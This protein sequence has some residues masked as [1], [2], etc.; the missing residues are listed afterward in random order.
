MEHIGILLQQETQIVWFNDL[1]SDPPGDPEKKSDIEKA[2]KSS[3]VWKNTPDPLLC[4]CSFYDWWYSIMHTA[5]VTKSN[6]ISFSSEGCCSYHSF[7]SF[8]ISRGPPANRHETALHVERQPCGTGSSRD[9]NA[10]TPDSPGLCKLA[11][12]IFF[13]KRQW[14]LGFLTN[15]ETWE[16]LSGTSFRCVD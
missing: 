13:E 11:G 15:M 4:S 2:S 1:C 3:L 8:F 12:L 7:S 5:W 16:T 6:Y 14:R 10:A 9:P